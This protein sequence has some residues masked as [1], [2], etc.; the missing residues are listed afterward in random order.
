M[1][2]LHYDFIKF[3]S[4]NI[5]ALPGHRVIFCKYPPMGYTSIEDIVNIKTQLELGKEYT[6]A[7]T[8]VARSW[9]TVFLKEIPGIGFDHLLFKDVIPQKEGLERRHPDYLFYQGLFLRRRSDS[10]F[11]DVE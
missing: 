4:M 2:K 7:R 9:T 11:K 3:Q 8:S 5:Y 1:K 10:D 6:V